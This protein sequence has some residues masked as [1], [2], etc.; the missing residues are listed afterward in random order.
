MAI[1]KFFHDYQKQFREDEIRRKVLRP[2]D[3]NYVLFHCDI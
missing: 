2:F 1:T 3:I